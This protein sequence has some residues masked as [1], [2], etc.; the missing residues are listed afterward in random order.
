[1][2]NPKQPYPA[3]FREQ[4]VEWIRAG[5][6]QGRTNLRVMCK[7]LKVSVSGFYGWLN[8]PM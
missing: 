1:M 5:R 6:K 2:P 4:M 8:R 7:T 3:Q